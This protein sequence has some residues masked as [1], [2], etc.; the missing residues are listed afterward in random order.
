MSLIG[1]NTNGQFVNEYLYSNKEI[2]FTGEKAIK[3]N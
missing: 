3:L 2:N 1:A